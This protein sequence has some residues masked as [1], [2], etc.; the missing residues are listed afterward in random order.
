MIALS[1]SKEIQR[2]PCFANKGVVCL[3]GAGLLGAE[4][5]AGW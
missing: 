3:L 1:H 4:L 2:V 5:G